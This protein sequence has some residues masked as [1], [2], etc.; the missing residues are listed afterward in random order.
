MRFI[1]NLPGNGG[2]LS[3]R[4]P[5]AEGYGLRGRGQARPRRF[6]GWTPQ[7][8]PPAARLRAVCIQ[9]PADLLWL[10]RAESSTGRQGDRHGKGSDAQQQG[11][12]ETEG[13]QEPQKGRRRAGQSVR[14]RQD[15]G[16]PE[17]EQQEELTPGV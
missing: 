9:K 6:A 2:A 15:P 12:E 5:A 17:P 13:R 16:R 8:K 3:G 7:N 10:A 14:V 11:K 1:V 4:P